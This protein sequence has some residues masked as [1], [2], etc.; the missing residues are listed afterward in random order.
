MVMSMLKEIPKISN[1]EWEVMKVLWEKKS[2]TTSAEIIE[3]LKQNIKWSPKTIHTL[4]SRLV[5][6][7]AIGIVE[8]SSPYL[9]YPLISE[10][11]C[12]RKETKSFLKRVYNNSL[13][14]LIANFIKELELSSQEI[15]ELKSIL[16]EKKK[17]KG[18]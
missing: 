13:S 7:K 10:E 4:I 11:E 8:G 9:Y 5:A 18:E 16:E 12:R 2:P 6:K 1:A 3:I 17:E 14:L 15:D